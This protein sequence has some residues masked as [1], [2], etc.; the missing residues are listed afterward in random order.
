MG[1]E[2]IEMWVESKVKNENG[3]LM[4]ET[5]IKT[6]CNYSNLTES[7]SKQAIDTEEKAVREALIRLG[8]T[9]PKEIKE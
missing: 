1:S 2:K 6:D 7:I 9:P 3:L 5:A 4:V 8:W